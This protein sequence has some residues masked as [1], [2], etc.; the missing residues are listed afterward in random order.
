VVVVQY[1]GTLEVANGGTLNVEG[2]ITLGS[3][4]EIVG[5]PEYPDGLCTIEIKN[6]G[7]ITGGGASNFYDEDGTPITGPIPAGTYVWTKGIGDDL[8]K[9]G[10]VE[11]QP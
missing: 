11:Q 7:S 5:S 10:W 1:E 3:T 4:A 8:N 2:T 6:G 9:E